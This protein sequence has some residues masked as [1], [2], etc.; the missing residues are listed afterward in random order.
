MK[1]YTSHNMRPVTA[2]TIGEAAQV[3][4]GRIARREHGRTAH[5]QTC[6]QQAI[7]HD[8]TYAEFG[9]WV[10]DDKTGQCSDVNFA[11]YAQ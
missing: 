2:K 11:V 10:G 9:A 1:I 8:G 6:I 5:V 4:A 7:T 3:F